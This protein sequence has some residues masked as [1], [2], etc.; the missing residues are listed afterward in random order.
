M[1]LAEEPEPADEPDEDGYTAVGPT[2]GVSGG[3]GAGPRPGLR[4]GAEGTS[5]GSQAARGDA[6]DAADDDERRQMKS[7]SSEDIDTMKYEMSRLLR[8][9][10]DRLAA[11]AAAKAEAQTVSALRSVDENALQPPMHVGGPFGTLVEGVG[12]CSVH[13]GGG[14]EISGGDGDESVRGGGGGALD[15]TGS[16]VAEGGARRWPG[17]R[18]PSVEPGPGGRRGRRFGLDTVTGMGGLFMNA[19]AQKRLASARETRQEQMEERMAARAGGWAA[20]GLHHTHSSRGL[21]LERTAAAAAAH[22]HRAGGGGGGAR[23]AG[24]GDYLR[25]IWHWW[26]ANSAWAAYRCAK[27]VVDSEDFDLLIIMS[28]F[29]NCISLVGPRPVRHCP[30][31]HRHTSAPSLLELNGILYDVASNMWQALVG[32][33]VPTDRGR[34]RR[35]EPHPAGAGALPQRRLH[36][37]RPLQG[38]WA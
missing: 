38:Q 13:G 33:A 16:E 29:V 19:L 18:Q 8:A 26:L 24:W 5:W 3:E 7:I 1:G 21:A 12:D 14:A 22:H 17:E 28:I 23:S 31:H 30:P 34:G 32:G 2:V 20:G 11:A 15:G 25:H 35:V 36:P 10:K 9:S 6:A 27:P 4:A 37:G